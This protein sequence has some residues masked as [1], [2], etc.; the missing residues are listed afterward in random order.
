MRSLEKERFI[1]VFKGSRKGELAT[2]GL[3]KIISPLI[4]NLNGVIKDVV[5]P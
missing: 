1:D 5:T 4:F 3:S 2:I